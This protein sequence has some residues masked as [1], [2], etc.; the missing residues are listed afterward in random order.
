MLSPRLSAISRGVSRI[1]TIPIGTLTN[2]IERHPSP[3]VST[4]PNSTPAA[5]PDPATAPHT[6]SARLRS[7]PSA[8]IEVTSDNAAG[9]SSAAPTP[10]IARAP[11]SHSALC[12]SPPSNEAAENTPRPTLKVRRRPTRSAIRLPSSRNPPKVSRYAL[13]THERLASEMCSPRPID[14]NAMFTIDASR[15]T[16]KSAVASNTSAHQRRSARPDL[17]AMVLVSDILRP[18]IETAFVHGAVL[19]LPAE[20]GA[21]DT[22]KSCGVSR[23]GLAKQLDAR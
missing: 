16:T 2:R 7:A 15:M 4:P 17:R 3:L 1:A 5:A 11:N 12:A 22:V 6:D 23:S 10:W 8:K 18:V 20:L 14:G 9:A 13:T 19:E 21:H